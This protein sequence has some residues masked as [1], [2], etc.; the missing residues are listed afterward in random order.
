MS[1]EHSKLMTFAIF[2][3]GRPIGPKNGAGGYGHATKLKDALRAANHLKKK[4]FYQDAKVWEII[5]YYGPRQIGSHDLDGNRLWE[6]D[7]GDAGYSD[8]PENPFMGVK[9][10]KCPSGMKYDDKLGGCVEK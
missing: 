4:P 6:E 3:D 10:N 5:V 7:G 2:V 1:Q 8:M 9:S